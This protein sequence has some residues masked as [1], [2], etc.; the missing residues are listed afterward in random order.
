MIILHIFSLTQTATV[1]YC[2]CA[3]VYKGITDLI[4]DLKQKLFYDLLTAGATQTKQYHNVLMNQ[5][6]E[7]DAQWYVM[8]KRSDV[9]VR[10]VFLLNVKCLFRYSI[11]HMKDQRG[12]RQECHWK[13][14]RNNLSGSSGSKHGVKKLI[15]RITKF[16]ISTEHAQ[17]VYKDSLSFSLRITNTQLYIA[18]VVKG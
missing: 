3:H 8:N 5:S 7:A 11:T 4:S 13:S 12:Q 17:V 6:R 9:A 14:K 18:F 2:T 1:G 16:S 15:H 10:Y